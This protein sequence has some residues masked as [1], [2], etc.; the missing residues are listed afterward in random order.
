M[1]MLSGAAQTGK[2]RYTREGDHE[3]IQCQ[4][5]ALPATIRKNLIAADGHSRSSW[6]IGD[7]VV[8]QAVHDGAGDQG[9]GRRT[10]AA[11]QTRKAAHDTGHAKAHG[12]GRER[13][14]DPAPA[15]DLAVEL[16][17]GEQDV[18]GVAHGGAGSGH[19]GDDGVLLLLKDRA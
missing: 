19:H 1:A 15:P 4:L 10:M 17:L 13:E 16:L 14:Q 5:K 8:V 7:V 11:G 18:E 2:F 12:L 3:G 9:P 6:R